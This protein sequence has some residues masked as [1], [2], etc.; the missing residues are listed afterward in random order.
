VLHR[1]RPSAVAG[2]AEAQA[3][4][5]ARAADW[6]RPGGTLVYSVCSLEAEEGEAVAERFL[7][8]RND[9]SIAAIGQEELIPGMTPTAE[10]WLR[11]LPGLFAEA[12]GADSFFIARFTRGGG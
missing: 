6:L 2:L 4:M 1:V 5:L 10:G 11:L 12:G 7:A 9:Y 3:A 8:G